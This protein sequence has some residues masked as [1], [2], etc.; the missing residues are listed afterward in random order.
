MSR[1]P[2]VPVL[3]CG[4][5]LLVVVAP[6]VYRAQSGETYRNFHAVDEGQLYRS[7]QMSPTGFART[8]RESGVRTVITLRDTADD[9]TGTFADQFEADYC[10]T[11]GIAY[12]RVG[13][14]T[15][16]LPTD[17]VKFPFHGQVN[18]FL[19]ITNDPA[20]EW[21]V[22]VHCFAGVHRT[23]ACCAV[24]R[25][26]HQ[27]WDADDAIREMRAMG[28]ARTTFGD[29]LLG[30]LREYEPGQERIGE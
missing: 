13:P 23:G 7:G 8:I 18:E 2:L 3:A 27:G 25:M 28:N 10:R 11:H 30:Y 5:A 19:R 17:E 24:Y 6:F 26:E 12:H 20:T 14:T 21:P 15:D 1:P 22:L 16:W 9:D 4:L 29:D